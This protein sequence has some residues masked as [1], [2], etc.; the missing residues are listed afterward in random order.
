M[1]V[2][3]HINQSIIE[4]TSGLANKHKAHRQTNKQT[5]K[6]HKAHHATPTPSS[7]QSVAA[8]DTTGDNAFIHPFIHPFIH[9]FNAIIHPLNAFIHVGY[10]LQA[11]RVNCHGATSS[12]ASG[13]TPHTTTTLDYLPPCICFLSKFLVLVHSFDLVPIIRL[14][15]VAFAA[16]SFD[17]FSRSSD[18]RNCP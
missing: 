6:H 10:L 4:S 16:S 1:I 7:S 18:S 9:S 5:N 3:E 17:R 8:T 14:L 15:L 11:K 12:I 13:Y 2:K